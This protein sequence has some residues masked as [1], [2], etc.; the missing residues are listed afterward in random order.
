MA[1]TF[2]GFCRRFHDVRIRAFVVLLFGACAVLGCDRQNRG[3]S[4][5]D[6]FD[7]DLRGVP[8]A[9]QLAEALKNTSMSIE[10]EPLR[11]REVENLKRYD[12]LVV[13]LQRPSERDAVGREIYG[14]WRSEPDNVLWIDLAVMEETYLGRGTEL[15]AMLAQ[16]ALAD[17]STPL[18]VYVRGLQAESWSERNQAMRRVSQWSAPVPPLLRIW[19][20]FMEAWVAGQIGA[21]REAVELLLDQLP[22][23][24]ALGGPRLEMFGWWRLTNALVRLRRL[25]DALHAAVMAQRCARAVESPY[26]IVQYGTTIADVLRRRNE[27]DAARVLL[28]RCMERAEDL[29]YPRRLAT[30]AEKIAE[31]LSADG[32]HAKALT[33]QYRLLNYLAAVGDS[34]NVPRSM[35]GIANYHRLLGQLDSCRV[36]Q[37]RANR[38]IDEYPDPVNRAVL[39]IKLIQ[40]HSLVGEFDVID[41]L[42]VAA[43]EQWPSSLPPNLPAEIYL[44]D[45]R[46]AIE[47]GRPADGYRTIAGIRDVAHRLV[48]MS[49]DESLAADIE[50]T[51]ADFLA[52]QGEYRRAH[53]ALARADVLLQ[54]EGGEYQRWFRD[55][56]RG[57]LFLMADDLVGARDALTACLASAEASGD[58]DRIATTR[59]CLGEVAL[60]L[61]DLD[62]AAG[63]FR[64]P[65]TDS[66]YGG[67][68][69]IQL[70]STIASARVAA[71]R[72]RH[73]EAIAICRD[74]E[75]LASRE[76]PVDLLVQLKTQRGRCLVALGENE[77]A[78][79][80]FRSALDQLRSTAN[81]YP[82]REER[83]FA[84]DLYLELLESLIGLY[85][86]VPSLMSP[87][88][89]PLHTLT[90][91]EEARWSVE[92][93]PEQRALDPE[94][95]ESLTDRID[96]PILAYFI[97]NERGFAWVISDGEITMHEMPPRSRLLPGVV[98]SLSCTALP[99]AVCDD[100]A[101]RALAETLLQPVIDRWKPG[102]HLRLV[103]HRE[104]RSLAWASLPWPESRSKKLMVDQGPL[105]E[106][107]SL[108]FLLRQAPTRNRN[109]G[110]QLLAIGLDGS[111]G[112]DGDRLDAAR[113][114]QA[115]REARDVA[116][117]WSDGTVT[118]RT[119]EA[120]TWQALQQLDLGS[121]AAIH[122]ATHAEVHQ[123]LPGRS[124]LR[125]ADRAGDG[126]AMTLAVVASLPLAADL[127]YLSCCEAARPLVDVEGMVDFARAFLT[128]GARTVVAASQPVADEAAKH[129]ALEFYA[130]WQRG[131]NPA[132][133]LRAAQLA[134]RDDPH[135]SHPFYWAAF[136]VVSG[137]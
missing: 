17:T 97:G 72:G 56:V 36:W 4:P 84:A 82:V 134:L 60:R 89:V 100:S 73:V 45:L 95:L 90:L 12:M 1:C 130:E 25:D 33:F 8:V 136:R 2:P 31:I 21:D 107:P 7:I 133:S 81:P 37:Q 38:W 53:E 67:N 99:D 54:R 40:Y 108:R 35:I 78:E 103:P 85:R 19:A 39:P 125:L 104:L 51:V 47:T 106:L 70:A 126:E 93:P 66:T 119:G 10:G 58:P 22:Q 88:T 52:S 41:S 111:I 94:D 55:F 27:T 86:D 116:A 91:A 75:R 26:R 69:R 76:P 13:G 112:D 20:T 79:R 117:A 14:L 16:P 71:R 127:V 49:A 64:P 43:R 137:E 5:E 110:H 65:P 105:S 87:E 50:V 34:V 11:N 74:A 109:T 77:T 132:V 129:L 128:A 61:G 29:D 80:E 30:S 63:W 135:W 57:K 92:M 28:Q 42:L 124:T 15:H 44:A 122:L 46:Q 18:G 131:S 113:L 121:F 62:G 23:M 48:D 6:P 68:F 123:G 96:G 115:E 98:A 120:A 24:R 102:Q 118:L 101:V 32:K 83:V 3:P 114:R 9:P 59:Y